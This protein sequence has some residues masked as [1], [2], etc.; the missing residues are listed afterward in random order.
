MMTDAGVK[1]QVRE[2]YDRVGWQCV[3]DCCYQNARFED[4]RPV[5]QEYIHKCHMRVMRHLASTGEY[6]LDAGSGPIQYPE[7]L[8]YSRGYRFRV[9]VDLSILALK[10]ARGRLGERGFYVVADVAYLPFEPERFEGV[11]SLHTIHHLPKEEHL[12]AYQEI[13]RVLA[14]GSRAVVVNGWRDSPLMKLLQP[15]MKVAV[16]IIDAYRRVRGRPGRASKER[17]YYSDGGQEDALPQK[18]HAVRRNYEWLM[19]EVAVRMPV[20]VHPWRSVSTPF[21]RTFVHRRLA[22]RWLLR[23]VYRLE[24][25]FPHFM[26]RYGQYPLIVLKKPGGK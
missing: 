25:W 10:E 11:V 16:I 24:E 14:D 5:T 2:F 20:E 13:Q 17:F 21:L 9:C 7:Y 4:L 18:T 3:G 12:Q 1:R 8:E 26:G 6:F 23:L 19:R 15:F 22:G